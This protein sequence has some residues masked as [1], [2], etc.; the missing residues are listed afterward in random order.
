MDDDLFLP[1]APVDTL[2]D[3]SAPKT[4]HDVIPT[5][6]TIPGSQNMPSMVPAAVPTTANQHPGADDDGTETESEDEAARPKPPPLGSLPSHPAPIPLI[7]KGTRRTGGGRGGV[8]LKM[9]VDAGILMPGIGVFTM[10]YKGMTQVADLTDQ[11]SI[12]CSIGGKE[13][14]FDSPSA[15]SIYLKRLVNPTRKADDGW[16]AVKYAGRLLETYKADLARE[17]IGGEP[18]NVTEPPPKRQRTTGISSQ[19]F[20]PPPLQPAPEEY[21]PVRPRRLAKVP[22]RFVALGVDDEHS[23]QPL[24]AYEPDTQP[25]EVQV[26]NGAEITMDFH[27]HLSTNEIIGIL[28]GTWDSQQKLI[29]V[30]KAIPVKELSTEDD[31]VNVEMDP[32]AEFAARQEVAAEGLK[33]VGWYHSHPTFPTQPS[34]IDIYN[35]VLQQHAHR[36]EGESGETLSEPYIAAIVGPFGQHLQTALSSI[37]WFFVD[38]PPGQVPSEGQS[39]EEAGCVAKALSLTTLYDD[40]KQELVLAAPKK[41]LQQLA[42]KYAPLPSAQVFDGAWRDGLNRRDKLAESL[43]QR[44]PKSMDEKKVA[45]FGMDI[46]VSVMAVWS[47]FGPKSAGISAVS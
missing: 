5:T 26:H 20:K 6:S 29:T 40:S 34:K 38:H 8:S 36:I 13:L 24:E 31:S 25:F 39:P 41:E 7:K 45:N 4:T 10:E 18:S 21:I 3:G 47:V 35:Q 15:F 2:L 46:M 17:K 11:G 14:S 30:I 37:S 43:K 12:R 9:L 27:A 44:L 33:I 23:L 22:T 42:K 1:S 16:K 32:E 28:A 19:Y